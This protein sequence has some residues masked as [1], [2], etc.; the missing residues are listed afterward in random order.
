M[1]NALAVPPT[2]PTSDAGAAAQLARLIHVLDKQP[3]CLIRVTR[4][5]ELLAVNDAALSLLGAR[6]LGEVFGTSFVDRFLP[7]QKDFWIQ[8]SARVWKDGSASAECDLVDLGGGE[9]AVL[10]QA[11]ARRDDDDGDSLFLALRDISIQ[12]R[13]ERAVETAARMQDGS[14]A[15]GR[16]LELARAECS[17]LAAAL[18]EAAEDRVRLQDAVRE[19]QEAAASVTRKAEALLEQ[20]QMR[21]AIEV[22]ER[23]RLEATLQRELRARQSD[24]AAAVRA[25]AT[26][27]GELTAQ[28]AGCQAAVA[29]LRAAVLGRQM[30]ECEA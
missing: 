27:E 16:E 24:E 8:F 21:L 6:A 10:L 11:L 1:A 9:R 22:A 18:A 7:E 5:G 4:D 3:A 15:A 2:E 19:K 28:F 25:F 23:K 14:R 26:A 30:A 29:D 20:I 12:R 13:L 17:R